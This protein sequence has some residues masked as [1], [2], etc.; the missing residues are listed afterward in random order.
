MTREQSMQA[1]PAGRGRPEPVTVK[2]LRCP[3]C[4][5]T[6]PWAPR[7]TICGRVL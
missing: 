1:H 2:S 6:V 4:G 3:T 5:I 7:C